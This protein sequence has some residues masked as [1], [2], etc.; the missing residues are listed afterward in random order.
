MRAVGCCS[1]WYL[2]LVAVVSS[3]SGIA[4]DGGVGLVSGCDN[5]WVREWLLEFGIWIAIG[6]RF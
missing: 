5:A 1:F 2:A 3:F 4:W 6:V